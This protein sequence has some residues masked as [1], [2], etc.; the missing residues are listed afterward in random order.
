MSCERTRTAPDGA[1]RFFEAAAII[2]Q[3]R[4]F[5]SCFSWPDLRCRE[6]MQERGENSR[7]DDRERFH[8]DT[9]KETDSACSRPGR[10]RLLSMR[11]KGCRR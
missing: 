3:I 11:L 10:S 1:E 9:K 2:K 4:R 7:H 8:A 5:R 6:Q